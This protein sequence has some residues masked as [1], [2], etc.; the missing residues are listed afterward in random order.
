MRGSGTRAGHVHSVPGS[1]ELMGLLLSEQ[2]CSWPLQ[3][4]LLSGPGL[5]HLWSGV[6]LGGCSNS[7]SHEGEGLPPWEEAGYLVGA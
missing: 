1:I 3:E 2:A 4:V 7:L 5:G 6:G